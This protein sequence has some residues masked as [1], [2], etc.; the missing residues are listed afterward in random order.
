MI[1]KNGDVLTLDDN[2]EYVVISKINYD[3]KI[4]YYLLDINDNTRPLF[5]YEDGDGVTKVNDKKLVT[6]LLPLFAD[7][8][9]K[10]MNNFN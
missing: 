6:K 8:A 9:I 1:I 7:D 5:C 2:N 3:E 4:Y 10:N